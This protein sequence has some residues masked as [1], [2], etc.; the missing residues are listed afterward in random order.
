[1]KC[2]GLVGYVETP[3]GLRALS[4]VWASHLSEEFKRRF[5]KNWYKSKKKCFSKYNKN[6]YGG[7][8]S[9]GKKSLE[10][11]YARIVNYCSVVRALVHTQPSKLKKTSI[12]QKKAHLM[13]VQVNGGTTQEKVDFIKSFYE[14]DVT[15]DQVFNHGE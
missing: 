1:M 13:E 8:D 5:Y 7:E 9:N 2:V 6:Y 11:Q 14:K 3:N 12:K 10:A 15:V 4:T